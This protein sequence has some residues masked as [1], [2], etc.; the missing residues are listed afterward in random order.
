MSSWILQKITNSRCMFICVLKALVKSVQWFFW[1]FANTDCIK[2][3]LQCHEESMSSCSCVA[4]FVW[5]TKQPGCP[6]RKNMLQLIIEISQTDCSLCL[7]NSII[8]LM[9]DSNLLAHL[10]QNQIKEQK[11]INGETTRSVI[12]SNQG[13]SGEDFF[14]RVWAEDKATGF[15]M[16]ILWPG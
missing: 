6:W 7:I 16:E 5:N 2:Q 10:V 15:V 11:Q 8:I 12:P 3:I 14:L 4:R 9:S 13:K 1:Y